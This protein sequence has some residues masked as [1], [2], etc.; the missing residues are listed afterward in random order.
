MT[1]EHFDSLFAFVI[2]ITGISLMVTALNQMVS[3]LLGLR[4][5]HLRWALETLLT[6]L[7]PS[8]NQYAKVISEK[9]L[10]HPLISDSVFSRFDWALFRRWKLAS[11]IRKDELI[12]ILHLL[13]NEPAGPPPK[14]PLALLPAPPGT[15]P[16][17]A[18]PPQ[19]GAQAPAPTPPP[20]VNNAP[21]QLLLTNS[22]QQVDPQATR[23]LQLVAADVRSLFPKDAAKADRLIAGMKAQATQLPAKIGQWFDSVMDRSAQR[24]TLHMR[25]WTVL[26]SIVIA[27]ALQL[28]AFSLFTRV[29]TDAELRARLVASA[30]ALTKK[31]DDV[32]ASGSNGVPSIVYLEAMKHLLAD[33]TNELAGVP[34]PSGFSTLDGAQLWLASAL[35]TA[36]IQDTN[37]SWS[38]RYA[39]RVPQAALR[40]AAANL[41]SLLGDQLSV[42]IMPESYPKPF[43]RDWALNRRT[44]WGICASAILLSFGAPFWFNILK[45]MSNLRP[46]LANRQDAQSQAAGKT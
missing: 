29:S 7:E 40:S 22:L 17:P 8:L 41:S 39:E 31:A 44:F 36:R 23:D 14:P 4:G 28:D 5:T 43:W 1:L 18:N 2:I 3:A 46:Q 25:I 20:V 21:W 15:P 9:V 30:D 12:D 11:A 35:K 27:F 26:F 37:N 33:F 16:A 24:F 34:S 38:S 32:L 13:A 6:N 19:P 45:T 42:Q 10:Q